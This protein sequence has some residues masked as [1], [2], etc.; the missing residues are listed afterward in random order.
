LLLLLAALAFPFLTFVCFSGWRQAQR[1]EA[2][3]GAQMLAVA[4]LTAARLDDHVGNIGELLRVL[5]YSVSAK[6]EDT[7]ANERLLR[8]LGAALP[9][10]IGNVS[11]WAADGRNAGS[12]RPGLR[13]HGID[14]LRRQVFHQ[15]LAGQEMAVQAPIESVFSGPLL[16]LFA[17][18]IRH[19]GRI[20][21]VVIAVVRLEPLQA[22]ITPRGA[23]PEG[24]VVTVTDV[25]GVVL[26]RSADPERWIG[27]NT[28]QDGLGGISSS[29]KR[30]D[31]VRTGSSADGT[32]RIA[33][34]TT[35]ARVPWLV[36]VGVPAETILAPARARLLENI[37]VGAFLLLVGIG[38]AF[39]MARGISHPLQTL[40]DD[41]ARLERGELAH[42]SAVR[43]G[44]EIGMLTEMINRMA[45]SLEQ[46]SV[47]LHATQEQ[48]RQITDNL[49][50]MISYVDGDWKVRFGNRACVEWLGLAPGA[51][52]DRSLEAV[53]GS[54]HYAALRP[55]VAIA[56][57]GVK[58]VVDSSIPGPQGQRH[59]STTLVPHVGPDAV[60][61]GLFVLS[62]D[63]TEARRADARRAMSEERLNLA[64][65]GSNAALF[66][67]D[68]ARDRIYNSA[69]AAVLRG[70]PAQE[71]VV[72]AEAIIQAIHPD[73]RRSARSAFLAA[74]AGASG[75]YDAEFR[76]R[77]IN[78]EWIWLRGRGRIVERDAGGQALR[79]AGTYIDVTDRKADEERLRRLA[80]IDP[81]TGI[82]NR[83]LFLDRLEHAVARSNRDGRP[84][85][86]LYLD[87]DRFKEVNDT[88]GHATGDHLLK[89]F[90]RVLQAAVRAS[91]TVARLGGD[92]FT[93]LLEGPVTLEDAQG[94]AQSLVDRTRALSTFL[95]L[96]HPVSASVGIVF[97]QAGAEDA[98]R[99]LRRAD[100][101]LYEAK[102]RGRDCW[103]GDA[104][105]PA[106]A[107][108]T[109]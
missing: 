79:L 69:Q 30:R 20:V 63:V 71:S 40:R 52:L 64:I 76:V 82:P 81:L 9:P 94:I 14:P 16:G 8:S 27:R 6:P 87:I 2:H 89:Q 78:G 53:Y 50:A 85:A 29:L 3:A 83:A 11:V 91:D 36:Y 25:S 32:H 57:T 51:L 42:R 96:D 73:D 22:L 67:Y 23:I 92:E 13:D 102:G 103:V 68:I 66:D 31:G 21:G 105:E 62:V 34:F 28:L 90:A 35:A 19:D 49:P 5:G 99:L 26:A 93:V 7:D 108:S 104:G 97:R 60:V 45:D 48:L 47:R 43:D 1:D 44:G 72:S 38:F 37:A 59:L 80:E 15:A 4:R 18:P 109:R 70:L 56:F 33:G 54:S 24:A 55:H 86:L 88:Y 39:R 100:A 101:A 10:H 41:A 95:R 74:I 46:R 12:L 106:E 75:R 58:V 107:G 98:P 84:L 77:T 17:S 61:Q 65:E